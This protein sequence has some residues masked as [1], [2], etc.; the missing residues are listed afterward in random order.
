MKLGFAF[1][2]ASLVFAISSSHAATPAKPK[3]G[4]WETEVQHPMMGR[5]KHSYCVDGSFDWS[6]TVPQQTQQKCA[7]KNLKQGASQVSFDVDCQLGEDA[8]G[9]TMTS[10]MVITGKLDTSYSFSMT[11]AMK[12]PGMPAAGA[13]KISM[14]GTSK[15]VGPCA[16]K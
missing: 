7:M 11:T 14:Q 2:V 5:Q 9:M 8:G 16:K 12:I 1:S 15:W 3:P 6:R 10:S 13:K 4:M